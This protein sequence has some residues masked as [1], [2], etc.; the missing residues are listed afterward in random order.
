MPRFSLETI[1]LE[2][3]LRHFALDDQSAFGGS[4]DLLYANAGSSFK[5][6]ETFVGN[7]NYSKV[8]HDFLY[9]FY[10]GKG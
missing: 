4:F 9:T 2:Y 8:A 7:L 1:I 6:K 3:H 5:Q 10:A